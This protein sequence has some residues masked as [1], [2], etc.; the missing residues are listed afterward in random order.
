MLH[1]EN[2]FRA[3]GPNSVNDPGLPRALVMDGLLGDVQMLRVPR[4]GL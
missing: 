3:F 2:I 4:Q 1:A